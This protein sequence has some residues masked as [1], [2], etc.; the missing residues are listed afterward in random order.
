LYRARNDDHRDNGHDMNDLADR[1]VLLT[2]A[3][4]GIGRELAKL[5]GAE[6]ARVAIVA[7]RSP[8]LEKLADEISAAGGSR[9]VIVCGDLSDRGSAADV[10]A[11]AIKH[12]GHV[13]VLINNAGGSVQGLSWVVGDR[14]EAREVFETNFWSPLALAAAVVP[15]MIARR[16]GT[17]VNV[18]SMVQVSPYPQLAQYCSSK[19]ALALATQTMRLELDAA[20]VRV[21]EAALGP[22]DS[23]ASAENRL[24]PGGD[25]WLEGSRLG[26]PSGAAAAILGALQGSSERVIYPRALRVAYSLPGLGRRYSRRAAKFVDVDDD[27][28][29]RGGS[30]GAADNQELRERWEKH[31]TA[32]VHK[33]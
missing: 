17:V 3:S 18:T 28:V 20:G 32:K 30:A 26:T 25:E 8:R 7:R 21:I 23:P 33:A 12:L 13:D 14:D 9:P 11:T 2:G 1:A 29:R 22:I 16:R 31:G 27:S 19:A 24:L 5:L 15:S 6:G 4:S 10:A